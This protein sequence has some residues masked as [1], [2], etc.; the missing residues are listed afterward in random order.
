[1]LSTLK[2]SS[3]K[4]DICGIMRNDMGK[5]YTLADEN[6]KNYVIVAGKFYPISSN[7]L[8]DNKL[9]SSGEI[10]NQLKSVRCHNVGIGWSDSEKDSRLHSR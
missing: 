7:K 1:M 6:G 9:H 3:T 2:D 8:E 5:S 10:V 4:R